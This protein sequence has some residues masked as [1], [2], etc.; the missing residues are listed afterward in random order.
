VLDD[1]MAVLRHRFERRVRAMEIE[2]PEDGASVY[3]DPVHLQQVLLNLVGN[4]MEYTRADP[5]RLLARRHGDWLEVSVRDL[6]DGVPPE[7]VETLFSKTG[8]GE[9]RR[10]RGGLGL[11]LYLCRLVV[12]RSLGGRVWLEDTGPG[13][14]TF[15]FTV[16]HAAAAA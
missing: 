9:A 1:T 16:P 11:G 2:I 15:S 4:A 3:C 5:I 8:P 6:G 14:T 12:E 13:G 10:T 7:R